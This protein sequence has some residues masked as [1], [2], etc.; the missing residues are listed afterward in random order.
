MYGN[1]EACINDCFNWQETLLKF[2]TKHDDIYF[3]HNPKMSEFYQLIN[4]LK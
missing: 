2:G 4:K 1:L 3:L